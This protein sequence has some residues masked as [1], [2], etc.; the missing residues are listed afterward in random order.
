MGTRSW[1]DPKAYAVV[2]SLLVVA[3][4]LAGGLAG[5]LWFPDAGRP[6]PPGAGSVARNIPHTDVNPIGAVFFL[7]WEAEPWK[8][9]KTLQMASEAGI[10]WVNQQFPWEELEP[11]KGKFWDDQ[12][13][14][15]N[16]AK[17]DRIVELARKYGMQVIARLDRPPAW[18]R[19]DN[20]FMAAPPDDFEDYGRFVSEVVRHYRGAIRYYQLWNEPNLQPEWGNRPID[21][22]AYTRLLKVG[23]EAVKA[24][25]PNAFVLSAP[26]AQTVERS[27]RALNDIEYLE[28]VYAAGGSAYFDIVA[29]NAYG[30]SLAPD[31]PP[32]ADRLN[33]QRVEL[34][35]RVMAKYGDEDKAVWFNEF[36]WNASPDAMPLAQ[37]VWGKVSEQ[38]QADY[39]V[40]AIQMA[41]RQWPWAGVFSIWYF[42]QSGHIPSE[43]SDYYFRMVDVGF[44]PRLAFHS[45]K[46]MA[47]GTQTAMAGE[48]QETNPAIRTEGAWALTTRDQAS[49]GL[50]LSGKRAGDSLTINFVGTDISLAVLK[51]AESG[52]ASITIDGKE[53]NRLPHDQQ[54]RSYLDL[55][56][57]EPLWQNRVLVASGLPNA[58]HTLR[59]AVSSTGN[60][61]ATGSNITV[62]GFAIQSDGEGQSFWP[63]VGVG[64]VA[65][66]AGLVLLWRRR[67]TP[68]GDA[69][70]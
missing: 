52:I 27:P 32:S 64:I 55:Y 24:A 33:F 1:R 10:G 56:S 46:T 48:Y 31:D 22:A 38:Q 58:K 50:V 45:V 21:P 19:Q 9:E 14:E 25:D 18:S 54:G 7:Q 65:L 8:V 16:F 28:G 60:P 41:R 66:V 6:G 61:A 13:N 39:T 44:T 59:L 57:A 47:A 36:G 53:A 63:S 30:F 3:V 20:T 69:G 35:R 29:A 43:R 15:S 70:K 2:V 37:L 12:R 51:D 11:R 67:Q 26:L 34:L 68:R 17:Y 42:R 23:Y 40:S 4:L 49:G 62:D 5:I